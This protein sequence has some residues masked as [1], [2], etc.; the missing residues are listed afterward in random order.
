MAENPFKN[1]QSNQEKLEVRVEIAKSDDWM[2]CKELRVIM[3]KGDDA[4]MFGITREGREE[5]IKEEEAE[6]ENEWKEKL[7]GDSAFGVLAWSDSKP[8]GIGLAK[9]REEKGDWYIYSGYVKPDS[10]G[11]V[12]K[13]ILATRLEEIQ[14]RGGKKVML[15]VK[16]TNATSISI[17][18]SFGFKKVEYAEN[19]EGF[20]M[21]LEDV[22]APEVIKKINEVLNA[23]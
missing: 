11:G 9:R 19:K 18:E 10:R 6:S 15:G 20:Y 8:I 12:G 22:N 23:G 7:S 2:V 13:K 5:I 1:K 17:A 3:C 16:A 14:R 21:E 4:E